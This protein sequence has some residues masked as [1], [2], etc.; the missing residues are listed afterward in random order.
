MNVLIL[1]C[2]NLTHW[3]KCSPVGV[4]SSDQLDGPLL[5]LEKRGWMDKLKTRRKG[6]FLQHVLSFREKSSLTLEIADFMTCSVKIWSSPRTQGSKKC[7]LHCAGISKG[8]MGVPGISLL[9]AQTEE[10]GAP[11]IFWKWCLSL[12]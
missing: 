7:A 9:T 10:E 2:E 5:F 12:S 3:G 1:R 11:T 4:L 6:Q 8:P